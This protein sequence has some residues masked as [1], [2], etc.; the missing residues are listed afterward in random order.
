LASGDVLITNSGTRWVGT[1]TEQGQRYVLEKTDGG[2]MMFPKAVVRDVIFSDDA[3]K[4]Y[5]EKLAATDLADDDAVAALADFTEEWGLT[6]ERQALVQKALELR[7]SQG[8]GDADRLRDLAA[9]CRHYGRQDDAEAAEL[10]ANR[11]EFKKKLAEAG[12]DAPELED[13]ARWCQARDMSAEVREC[14]AEIHTQ[15]QQQA[16]TAQAKWELAEWCSGWNVV[17][18]RDENQLAAIEE[19][20]ADT[21]IVLL[22]RFLREC[23]EGGSSPAVANHCARSVYRARYASAEDDAVTLAQLANW[24]RERSLN[25]EAETAEEKALE[26]GPDDAAVRGLLGYVRDEVTGGWRKPTAHLFDPKDYDAGKYDEPFPLLGRITGQ[27]GREVEVLLY[28]AK[29]GTHEVTF[30]ADLEVAGNSDVSLRKGSVIVFRG[31]PDPSVF[32]IRGTGPNYSM[33]HFTLTFHGT[34]ILR[35]ATDAEKREFNRKADVGRRRRND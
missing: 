29:V 24:C 26:L 3:R 6:E 10:Q 8:A 30:E 28:Q 9:W 11:I 4:T 1:V 16:K 7:Q 12:T 2:R 27:D 34:E 13:L 5:E 23:D 35:A 17:A 14:L 31:T 32:V 21:D 15:R 22:E 20:E 25:A 18:W 19:A 33:A